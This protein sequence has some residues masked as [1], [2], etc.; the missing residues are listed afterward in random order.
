MEQRAIARREASGALRLLYSEPSP[1]EGCAGPL[2]GW[3]YIYIHIYV[4]LKAVAFVEI[5]CYDMHT[6]FLEITE[7]WV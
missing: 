5:H 2:P 6:E 7:N 3:I 1:P 4:L